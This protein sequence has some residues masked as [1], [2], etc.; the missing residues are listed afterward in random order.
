MPPD[1]ARHFRR[2]LPDIKTIGRPSS[3]VSSRSRRSTSAVP[4]LA[5]MRMASLSVPITTPRAAHQNRL[6]WQMVNHQSG[7]F[8]RAVFFPSN[9]Q[10]AHNRDGLK[11]Q[12]GL[13]ARHRYCRTNARSTRHNAANPKRCGYSRIRPV[14]PTACRVPM[15]PARPNAACQVSKYVADAICHWQIRQAAHSRQRQ[16][17]KDGDDAPI[18]EK[19]SVAVNEMTRFQ[20]CPIASPSNRIVDILPFSRRWVMKRNCAGASAKKA[21]NL[22]G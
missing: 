5:A 13:A 19:A 12:Y 10:P 4:R 8:A 7:L 9:C 14:Q 18:G 6:V 2:I 17:D 22:H 11:R 20:L 21:R 3:A 15:F 1:I 16:T